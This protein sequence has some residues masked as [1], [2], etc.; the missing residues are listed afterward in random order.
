MVRWAL[1]EQKCSTPLLS[2]SN[3]CLPEGGVGKEVK[4]IV[5]VFVELG[6]VYYV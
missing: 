4:L 5:L 6:E 2:L 3:R 1:M